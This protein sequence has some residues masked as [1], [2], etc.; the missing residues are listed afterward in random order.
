MSHFVQVNGRS[1]E[2]IRDKLSKLFSLEYSVSRDEISAFVALLGLIRYH[3]QD[4]PEIWR[5]LLNLMFYYSRSPAEQEAE[6][7]TT[8]GILLERHSDL[9]QS[10]ISMLPRKNGSSEPNI[11]AKLPR[12]RKL[13]IF[14]RKQNQ[15]LRSSQYRTTN[16]PKRLKNRHWT[17]PVMITYV[18]YLAEL[19]IW[20]LP[21]FFQWYNSIFIIIIQ[22]TIQGVNSMWNVKI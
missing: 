10:L 8:I 6:I 19:I 2:E 12:K 13:K 20:R 3:Y 18:T 4:Q 1:S 15:Q 16:N 14:R 9:S 5:T 7:L 21:Y 11:L 22:D 17:A